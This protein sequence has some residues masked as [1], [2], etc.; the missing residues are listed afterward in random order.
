MNELIPLTIIVCIANTW[1]SLFLC[2]I[3][4]D[5]EKSFAVQ[6]LF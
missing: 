2:A 4:T 1:Y 6:K 3:D 5:T